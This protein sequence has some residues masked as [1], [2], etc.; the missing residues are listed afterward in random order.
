MVGLAL[1]R[2]LGWSR[3]QIAAECCC[4][5]CKVYIAVCRKQKRNERG[6]KVKRGGDSARTGMRRARNSVTSS[7]V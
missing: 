4:G 1:E 7:Q 3:G 6:S 2:S 5:V